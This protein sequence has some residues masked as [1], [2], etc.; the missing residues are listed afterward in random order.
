MSKATSV[1][2][3]SGGRRNDSGNGWPRKGT[4][5]RQRILGVDRGGCS[6]SQ[7]RVA[8]R[9]VRTTRQ[10]AQGPVLGLR[11]FGRAAAAACAERARDVREKTSEEARPNDEKYRKS[12]H[13]KG[14]GPH[15]APPIVAQPAP[16]VANRNTVSA[17]IRPDWSPRPPSK[18]C[19]QAPILNRLI[20]GRLGFFAVVRVE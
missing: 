6:G 13:W 9:A 12:S 3:G 7:R 11:H 17:R 1:E 2:L 16:G 18:R 20:R 15:C 14:S 8:K 10:L 19:F 5:I 4:R